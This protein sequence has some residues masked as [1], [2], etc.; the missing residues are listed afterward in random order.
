[1]SK[2][3]FITG[4]VRSGKS[5]FA[6]KYAKQLYEKFNRNYL[7]YIASGVP[8]DD[9]MTDRIK[10]HREDREKSSPQWNTI[11]IEHELKFDEVINLDKCVILWDCITTWLNNVLYNTE[12]LDE[13]LR[14]L[15]IEKYIEQL[16]TQ[17]LQ[18]KERGSIVLLVSNEIL[19]EPNSTFSEVNDYRFLLG[20]LHQWIVHHSDEAYEMN[21]SKLKRWK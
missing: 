10:R 16:K 18:W 2:L 7:Y 19:D 20:E 3:I 15:E 4:G 6:E 17:L 5:A 9:E 14:N 13:N 11:E 8:F 12:L 1:M 21:Y